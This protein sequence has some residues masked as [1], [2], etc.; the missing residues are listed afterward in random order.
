MRQPQCWLC[1]AIARSQAKLE[2]LDESPICT[3]H[4]PALADALLVRLDFMEL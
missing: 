2:A 1:Q 4:V 3:D